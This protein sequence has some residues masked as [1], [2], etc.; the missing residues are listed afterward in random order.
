MKKLIASL[1]MFLFSA[2]MAMADVHYAESIEDTSVVSDKAVLK[3]M[4]ITPNGC[5]SQPFLCQVSLPNNA[6]R[7]ARYTRSFTCID[8]SG[9]T[10]PFPPYNYKTVTD[11]GITDPFLTGTGL[12]SCGSGWVLGK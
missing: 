8:T 11:I 12:P 2:G 7:T 5:R 6:P 10:Y 9:P 3:M 4:T 1:A